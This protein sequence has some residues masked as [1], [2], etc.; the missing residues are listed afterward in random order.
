MKYISN[1]KNY[2]PSLK[3][4]CW[5]DEDKKEIYLDTER[6]TI[7]SSCISGYVR[8]DGNRQLDELNPSIGEYDVTQS[9]VFVGCAPNGNLS[10]LIKAVEGAILGCNTILK[11]TI[12]HKE[13]IADVEGIDLTKFTDVSLIKVE[14]D[15]KAIEIINECN[16]IDI[17]IC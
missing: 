14:Y 6:V 11:N 9:L 15:Y 8:F 16:D 4:V 12:T 10:N 3:Y 5:F 2:F 13:E 7:D 17:C 1:L